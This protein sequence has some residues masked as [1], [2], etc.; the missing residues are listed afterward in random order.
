MSDAPIPGDS[1]RVR[2]GQAGVR[3]RPGL[4]HGGRRTPPGKNQKITFAAS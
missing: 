3:T 1:E 2:G 4:S